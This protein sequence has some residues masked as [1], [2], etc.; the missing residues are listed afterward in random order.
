MCVPVAHGLQ[1]S[2]SIVFMNELHFFDVG[3]ASIRKMDWDLHRNSKDFCGKFLE[4]ETNAS[5]ALCA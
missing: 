1:C 5:L 2:N 3:V 4:I